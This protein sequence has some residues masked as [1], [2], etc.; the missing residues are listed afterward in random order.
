ML[1]I[2]IIC[3]ILFI[4]IIIIEFIIIRNIYKL[5]NSIFNNLEMVEEIFQ[6]QYEINTE[7]LKRLNSLENKVK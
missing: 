7:H 6:K 4:V 2:S 1:N 5:L 3:V